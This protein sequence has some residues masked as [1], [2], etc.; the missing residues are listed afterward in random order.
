[1]KHIA[2]MAQDGLALAL[3]P[4]HGVLDGDIVFAAATARHPRPADLRDL[5]EIGALAAST[6]AR[7]IARGIYEARSLPFPDALPAWRD[8]F[9]AAGSDKG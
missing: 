3:R 9:G 7:A 1:L 4:A 2:I 8:K 6:L 5:T